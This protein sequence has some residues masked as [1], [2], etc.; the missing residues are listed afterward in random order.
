MTCK[1]IG[2]GSRG[3]KCD[4]NPACKKYHDCCTDY[5]DLCVATDSPLKKDDAET[6]NE[7]V[8]DAEEEDADD[9]DMTEDIV[10]GKSRATSKMPKLSKACLEAQEE[11]TKAATWAK[12]SGFY[13]HP[14]WYKGLKATSSK[15]DFKKLLAK[16]K[17]GSCHK[18]CA[19]ENGMVFLKK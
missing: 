16:T 5:K 2:C 19:G 9:S 11:C 3:T 4:C 18:V 17:R 7:D 12:G 13:E 10:V 8:V 1:E 15:D 6:D 14:E